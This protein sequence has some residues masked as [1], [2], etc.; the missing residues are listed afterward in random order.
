[1]GRCKWCKKSFH[2][3]KQFRVYC[4]FFCRKNAHKIYQKKKYK[5]FKS[6]YWSKLQGKAVLLKSSYELTYCQY[7]DKNNIKWLY[8]PKKFYME[9]G[10]TYYIPD[11]YL[12]EKN[13]WRE[14]KGKWYEK[15]KIKFASFKKLYP[16]DIIKVVDKPQIM[17]I[18]KILREENKRKWE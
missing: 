13:E 12:P 6:Y 18:R 17:N 9:D 8:E 3:S 14:V 10:K 1:M 11:F 15:S 5:P 2:K 7:L 16:N 4:S